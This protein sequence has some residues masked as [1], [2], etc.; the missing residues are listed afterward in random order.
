MAVIRFPEGQQRS[1]STGGTVYSHNRFGAYIRARS[2]PVNP[3]TD[4]QVASRNRMRA[5]SI[6]WQ[7][8]LTQVQRDAWEVYAANVT[9]K[10]ALGD[11]VHLTGL[12]HYVRSNAAVLA[13][14]LTR[15]DAAPT[16]FTIAAAEDGLVPTASEATQDVTVA[17]DTAGLWCSEDGAAQLIYQGLPKNASTKFFGGPYRLLGVILGDS[18]AP[19][20]VPEVLAAVFPF[21]EG[22]RL[23]VRSRIL[24]ADGRLSDFAVA[25]F[26]GA[27]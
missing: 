6:A 10:N 24:R 12:N 7:N 17:F 14:G 15:V 26:L 4:R 16:V 8:L 25:N 22:N 5:L 21:A 19:P 20:A 2:V 18:V 27:A 11:S 23:W 3:N 1:G 9:W 13:A